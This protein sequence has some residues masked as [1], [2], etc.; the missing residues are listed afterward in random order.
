M[1]LYP[2]FKSSK[3]K[4]SIFDKWLSFFPF[5]K[6]NKIGDFVDHVHGNRALSTTITSY[7]LYLRG[8]LTQMC[9]LRPTDACNMA[10]LRSV[11]PI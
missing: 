4:I 5:I 3:I 7:H 11:I 10:N 9:C 6:G 2:V 1:I 8:R